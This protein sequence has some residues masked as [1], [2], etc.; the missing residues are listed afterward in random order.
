MFKQ[1]LVLS[2]ALSSASA[3]AASY[4]MLRGMIITHQGTVRSTDGSTSHNL[5]VQKITSR[6]EQQI[7]RHV[8][9]YDV[10]DGTKTLSQE[11]DD[12]YA[13]DVF[14]TKTRIDAFLKKCEDE[15]K[16]RWIAVGKKTYRGCPQSQNLDGGAR[17]LMWIGKVPY[18]NLH[19]EFKAADGSVQIYDYAG[20]VYPT[21]R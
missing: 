4:D 1:S 3:Q 17:S 7:K 20:T 21:S 8:K 19:S 15:G 18:G 10:V 5:I 6:D 9:M 13:P 14:W 16:M 2:L 11:F 12:A